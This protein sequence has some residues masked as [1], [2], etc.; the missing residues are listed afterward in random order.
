MSQYRNSRYI[1]DAFVRKCAARKSVVMKA[2][3]G[4]AIFAGEGGTMLWAEGAPSG[5]AESG[6]IPLSLSTETPAMQYDEVLVLGDKGYNP[7]KISSPKYTQ[8]LRDIPQTITV[9]PKAVMQDQNATSL[10]D[11]LRNVPGISM[12]A[13]EG[14]VPAGD[15]LTLRGFTA[16]TDMYTDGVRDF[17]GYTRDAFNLDSVE[18]SKGPSSSTGGRGAT[19]GSINQVSKSPALENFIEANAGVGN[20]EY[21]RA[22]IDVNRELPNSKVKGLA[23][24]LNALYHD[25]DV[26]RRDEVHNNRVG[27]AP[28]LA[29]GLGTPSRLT[30]SYYYLTQDNMPDYGIPWVPATQ[31]ALAGLRDN[32]AP[33]DPSNFYGLKARDYE[34]TDT[35]M[36][37]AKYE[38]DVNEHVSLRYLLRY[39]SSNRDSIVTAPRFV[40]D[41]TTNINRQ[42]QS[43]DMLDQVLANQ[44]DV[45]TKFNTFGVKHEVVTGVEFL[46]ENSVNRVRIATQNVTPVAELA[47]PNPNQDYIPNHLM[48]P[49]KTEGKAKTTALYAFDT[50]E[51][52][53]FVELSGGARFDSVDTDFNTVGA[54]GTVTPTS[55]VDKVVSGRGG[56][57]IKPVEF[58]SIYAAMGTSFNPSSEAGGIAQGGTLTLTTTT[59]LIDPERTTTVEIGT[60]WELMNKR[61]NLTGAVFRTEKMNARTPGLPGEPS[62]VLSGIQRV[63]G[64]ELGLGGNLLRGWDIFANY[65]FLKTEIVKSN[66]PNETGKEIQQTPDH[67][68]NIWSTYLI[69]IVRLQVGAGMQYVGRRFG[70]NTNTRQVPAYH[71]FDAMASYPVARNVNLQ[72]NVTNVADAV[73]F[74]SLG[75]GHLI[76]GQGRLIVLSTNVKF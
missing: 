66:A 38:R 18:V 23:F 27:L 32:P 4:A 57:V 14:G 26:P 33:V 65:T 73:Y 9:V 69:P 22:A 1:F 36:A 15:N 17:G 28:S 30:L 2:A 19:G 58:G 52:G 59:A 12:A 16:R 56:I 64:L 50:V 70:N 25:A 46:E 68:F 6:D 24:R 76:P 53:R 62:T 8:P 43:R 5:A 60:K 41:N 39:G 13:G 75:G 49:G 34:K 40:N 20:D 42:L 7:E 35:K 37:T 61:L 67:S 54:T 31:N 29:I 48:T 71:L 51:I 63:D 11:V 45:T 10:R 44:L 55:R 3:L 72:L 47:N 21:R 74:D